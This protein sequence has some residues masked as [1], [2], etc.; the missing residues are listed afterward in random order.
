MHL[1]LCL[2]EGSSIFLCSIYISVL[3]GHQE[4][5]QRRLTSMGMEH[6]FTFITLEKKRMYY[7]I[8]S[9]ASQECDCP[10]DAASTNLHTRLP[11]WQP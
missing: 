8:P 1:I 7:S 4:E 5:D 11:L 6:D 3:L 2:L 9:M 10:Y